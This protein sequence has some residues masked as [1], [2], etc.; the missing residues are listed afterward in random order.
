MIEQA[1]FDLEAYIMGRLSTEENEEITAHLIG[2]DECF[3]AVERIW[4]KHT[5]MLT[6]AHSP[7]SGERAARLEKRLFTEIHRGDLMV[8]VLRFAVV[9]FGEVL[10]ALLLPFLG[11]N[12]SSEKEKDK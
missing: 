6:T 9:G 8:E 2:C 11:K 4:K 1:H 3:E 12:H 10:K 5:S 7:L